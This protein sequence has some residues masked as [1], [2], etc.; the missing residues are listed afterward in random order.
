MIQQLSKDITILYVDD[1]EVNLFLFERSFSEKYK[2]ETALSGEEGLDLLKKHSNEAIVVISDQRMPTMSGIEFVQAAKKS[3]NNIIF[4]IL[5]GFEYN[6]DIDDAIQ[7][8]YVEKFFTKPFNFEEIDR[9]IEKL[10]NK[11]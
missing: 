8:K 10:I 7:N 9:A 2:V 3:N 11:S 1:E 6:N 5:T 4:F